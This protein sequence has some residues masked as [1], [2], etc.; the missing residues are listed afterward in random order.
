MIGNLLPVGTRS[1]DTL[2]KS[3]DFIVVPIARAFRSFDGYRLES[4]H[5]ARLGIFKYAIQL[6]GTE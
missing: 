2:G 5:R 1:L 4:F 6:F 3:S